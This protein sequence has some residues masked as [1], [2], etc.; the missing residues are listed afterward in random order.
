MKISEN[1]AMLFHSAWLI[2]FGL[3]SL[4][5]IKIPMSIMYVLGIITGILL[6]ISK[7]KL[8]GN[9]GRFLLGIWL[10]V[11]GL[12]PFIALDIPYFQIIMNIL[13]ICTGVFILLKR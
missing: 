7:A 1:L 4:T 8:S 11:T 12:F 10:I 3:L 9:L 6:L 13:A 2:L 5:G